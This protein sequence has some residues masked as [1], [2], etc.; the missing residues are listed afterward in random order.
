MS[1]S[2]RVERKLEG[3][4]TTTLKKLRYL[5]AK[6]YAELKNPLLCEVGGSEILCTK[7]SLVS[8]L[9]FYKKELMH[10]MQLIEDIL[11]QLI[12][13]NIILFALPYA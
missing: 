8:I 4:T 11:H 12:W 13:F 3:D 2:T 9:V 5:R 6:I 10:L 7:N 1:Q